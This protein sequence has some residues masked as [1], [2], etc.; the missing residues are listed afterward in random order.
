MAIQN[1][2]MDHLMENKYV[3]LW[4]REIFVKWFWKNEI[5]TAKL[6]FDGY[7]DDGR[8]KFPSLQSY[9]YIKKNKKIFLNNPNSQLLKN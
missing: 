2:F 1:F 4:M 6:N 5:L 3:W 7:L 9:N 8:F